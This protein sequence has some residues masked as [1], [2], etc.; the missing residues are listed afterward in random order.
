MPIV[1][2]VVGVVQAFDGA[3]IGEIIGDVIG[4]A[5][6]TAVN[7]A[8]WTTLLFAVL[9]R[10]PDVRVP[11]LREWTLDQLPE[12]PSRRRRY[13]DLIAET[14][15]LALF[16]AFVLVSPV[17]RIKTD[18]AGDPIGILSPWLWDTGVVYGFVFLALAGLSFNYVKMYTRWSAPSP[19]PARRSTS[20]PQS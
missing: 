16:A 3:G 19:S 17:L 5:I 8:F 4:A 20:R 15:A 10:L 7:V 1:A 11:V 18:A 13:A 6:T 14:V 9:E 2:T 12:P